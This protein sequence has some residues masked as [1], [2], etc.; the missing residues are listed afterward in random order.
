[1]WK[2]FFSFMILLLV[3]DSAWVIGAGKIHSNVVQSVQKSPLKVNIVAA[4]LFYVLAPIGYVYI[5]K[6]L[7]T[8]TKSAFLYG[9]LLGL[10]MYGTFDLTNKAIFENYPWP[11]AIADLTWGTMAVGVVSALTYKFL[12]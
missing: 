6:K 9:M 2:D 4:L 10:L 11:Y 8:D 12:I 7:A 3:I 1:M 5:T